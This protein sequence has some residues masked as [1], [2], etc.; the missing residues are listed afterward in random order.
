MCNRRVIDI[1]IILIFLIFSSGFY[2][3][4]YGNLSQV[5]L[6]FVQDWVLIFTGIVLLWYTDET[7]KIRQNGAAQNELFIRQGELRIRPFIVIERH[8]TRLVAKNVG[9]GTALNIQV[10]PISRPT[11]INSDCIHLSFKK[12]SFLE[13]GN[14]AD[15]DSTTK[16]ND[17][18]IEGGI[19]LIDPEYALGEIEVKITFTNMDEKSYSNMQTISSGEEA[20]HRV[21]ES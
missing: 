15:I 21:T 20:I 18:E 6:M 9:Q 2:V 17:Q 11:G 13:P 3:R 8:E 7:K 19:A 12:L 10:N 5:W 16:H 1:S 4:D 14:T